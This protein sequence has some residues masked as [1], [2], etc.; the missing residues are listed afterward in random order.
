MKLIIQIPCHNEAQEISNTIKSLPSSLEGFDCVEYLIVDDGSDDHTAE[1]ALEAG[2]HHIVRL[3]GHMGL[4]VAFTSGLDASVKNGADIIV[5]T[6]AD[7]QYHAAD[8]NLLVRPILEGRAQIVVGDRGVAT[9]QNFSPVKRLLQRMGSWVV[10]RIS[11]MNIPDATSGFRA[12]TREAALHTLVLNDYSYTL[13]TLIQAGARRIPVEYVKIRTNPQTRPSR[14]IRSVPHY[15]ANSSTTIVRS[16]TLY[17]PLRVFTILGSVFILG[18]LALAGR[19]LY[20][21]FN[22]QGSGHLQSVILA[23]VLLIVGFQVLL[24]GLVADLIGFNRKILEELL[25]KVRLLELNKS[26]TKKDASGPS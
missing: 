26:D 12:L 11:G 15:L 9:S 10:A 18:G 21:Y 25:Y 19:F 24:I 16:Y 3:P 2:A 20:F 7:N 14:L 13:E 1:V 23:A 5:N 17:R 8:I 4:A 22:G 6:D